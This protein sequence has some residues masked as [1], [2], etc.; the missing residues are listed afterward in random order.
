M[1]AQAELIIGD[2]FIE[3]EEYQEAVHAYSRAEGKVKELG[4]E[5]LDQAR[6]KLKKAN[7]L[8]EQSKKKQY[9]KVRNKPVFG[10]GLFWFIFSKQCY[11]CRRRGRRVFVFCFCFLYLQAVLKGAGQANFFFFFFSSEGWVKK[12]PQFP[13]MC[14]P[15][16]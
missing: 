6:E 7:I 9:Y 2:V 8:L 1:G 3:K 12:S 10:F 14:R 5:F 11:C 16:D 4:G 13:R 15:S